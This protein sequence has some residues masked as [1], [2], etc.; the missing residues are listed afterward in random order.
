MKTLFLNAVIFF[1][2]FNAVK[3]QN[4]HLTLFGGI[5][6][7]QGD[8]QSKRFTFQQAKGAVGAGVLYEIT[9]KL[10]IRG[11]V[12]FG[13]LNGD[14][15]KSSINAVRNLSFSSPVTD[16]HLGL[17]YDLLNSYERNFA[18]YVF[19][20]VSAFHFNPSTLDSTGAKVIL[21]PLGTE[22][23]GFFLGR[24]KYKLTQLALPF[25]GGVKFS[26]TE[27]IRVRF[28]IGLRK[29]FTDYLD[30]LSSTYA[31]QALLILNNGQRSADLAFRGDE[32]KGSGALY[33]E[34]NSK[35]GNSGSKDWYY[36]AGAGISFRL[37]PRFE[38]AGG[39]GRSKTG[40]PVNIY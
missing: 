37:S 15:A 38:I 33:P 26:L 30:D 4:L 25:G 27:N 9:Q 10:Y 8:L 40:C 31:D 11:N 22:G 17:E 18:P 6:N 23:Q 20:G 34:A 13:K 5:S 1:L 14:D 3:A 24:T 16:L 32:L 28:E 39:A 12:T 2:G 7:Y 19:A 29:T 21:Q 36:F 35:R